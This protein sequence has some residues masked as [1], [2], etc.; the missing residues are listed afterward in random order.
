M[1]HPKGAGAKAQSFAKPQ[2]RLERNNEEP[3]R[4]NYV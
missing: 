2:R 3:E 1:F 4:D